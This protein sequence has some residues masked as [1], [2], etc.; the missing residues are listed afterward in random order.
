M[1]QILT[2]N[3]GILFLNLLVVAFR[4]TS[5]EELRPELS[6]ENGVYYTDDAVF[7]TGKSYILIIININ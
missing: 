2:L 3:Y 7:I 1:K 5:G 6:A 4:I